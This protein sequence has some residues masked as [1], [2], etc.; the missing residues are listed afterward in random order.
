MEL[1]VRRAESGDYAALC[2][3]LEG[4]DRLHRERLPHVFRAPEGPAR[5]R[6]Y[7]EGLLQDAQ[8]LVLLAEADGEAAGC[9]VALL[10]ARPPLPIFVP[11]Q[12]VLVDALA[13]DPAWQRRG[14][15]RALMAGAD[16]WAAENG[17]DVVELNVHEFNGGAVAFYQALGYQ[18]VMRRMARDT[19]RITRR[20]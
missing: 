18:T 16:A 3:L 17:A 7:I 1:V 20:T 2:R 4:V 13:V 12:T 15:G 14:I 8:A 10:R 19:R 5:S 6:E 11:G 9:L